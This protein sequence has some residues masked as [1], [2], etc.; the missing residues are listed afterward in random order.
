MREWLKRVSV[1]DIIS[2]VAI[3][4]GLIVVY[5]YI[6][7]QKREYNF[8]D[9]KQP[10]ELDKDAYK[11]GEVINGFFYGEIYTS[12]Q[13]II[14]RRLEC[15]DQ[16]LSLR[17]IVV[18]GASPS[19]LTGKKVPIIELSESAL[20][21]D[22]ATIEPDT[23]CTL[24]ICNSYQVQPVFGNTRNLNECYA[25]A[26]FEIL[27]AE[28]KK[29]EP[30]DE[31]TDQSAPVPQPAQPIQAAPQTEPREVEPTQLERQQAVAPREE[32]TATAETTDQSTDTQ[33]EPNPGLVGR[34]INNLLGGE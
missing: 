27:A 1:G 33:D 11:V 7:D 30:K 34:I 2:V 19:K 15:K 16:R 8:V 4:F 31:A 6:T 22:G 12:N 18:S 5:I 32:E 26:K 14:V 9:I 3:I 13:P 10:V 28:K 21:V 29:Q 24:I 20:S 25:T 23:N 17:P